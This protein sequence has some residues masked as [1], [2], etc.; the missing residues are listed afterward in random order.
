MQSPY[1]FSQQLLG[2]LIG[3]PVVGLVFGVLARGW[4]NTV[5]GGAASKK[6][7]A[8]QRK[9]VLAMIGAGWIVGFGEVILFHFIRH[10]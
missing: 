6:T 1:P 3:A 7:V 5:Q 4:A 8:R 10:P 2:V 9:E